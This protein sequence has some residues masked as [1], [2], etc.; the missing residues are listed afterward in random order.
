MA[1]TNVA[2]LKP[3]IS[4]TRKSQL[5]KKWL[6][7][8]M[9]LLAITCLV[10]A[11]AQPY[12][13]AAT[14]ETSQKQTVIYLD[15]S[16][17]MQASGTNGA[18]YDSAVKE[19]L[20]QLPANKEFT[21][22]TNDNTYPR[23]TKKTVSNQLLQSGYSSRKMSF[24]DIEL[25]AFSLLNDPKLTSEFIALSD[26]Q[27]FNNEDTEVPFQSLAAKKVKFTPVAVENISIDSAFL[28]T[29]NNG[30]LKVMLSSNF[31]N[32][33]PVTLTLENQNLLVS[34]TAVTLN[35][36]SALA[37][38]DLPDLE[39]FNGSLSIQD[40]GLQF[41]NELFLSF[42][43]SQQINVLAI[44]ESDDSFLKKIFNDERFNLITRP[45]AQANYN[46]IKDQN[47]VILNE[48][49]SIPATLANEINTLTNNG[50]QVLIIPSKTSNNY[51]ALTKGRI[52]ILAED[53]KKITTINYDHPIFK[54]VFNKRVENF[55][56]P[57]VSFKTAPIYAT[58]S[59]LKFEDGSSFLYQNDAVFIFTAPI[60]QE[61]S[62]FQNSPI[63]VPVLYNMAM[64]S[65][66]LPEL[67]QNL[68]SNK[69][70]AIPV[71][72]TGDDILKITTTAGQEFIP[73]QRSYNTYTVITAGDELS[74]AGNYEVLLK[75]ATVGVLSFND[76][77]A[78]NNLDYF[79][80]EEL[81]ADT[82]V[83][84]SDLFLDLSDEEK[85]NTLWAW[86]IA[87]T[88][89]FLCCELLILKFVK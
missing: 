25:K 3:L 22:F 40:S 58:N 41:D 13:P 73:L 81:G 6:V 39:K 84:V 32:Q 57:S 65:L 9:R 64:S 76:L 69:D 87:G 4:Q 89:F 62:N 72:A 80:T 17:S 15:N 28:S 18:L 35:D 78:E 24:K 47:F 63:I 30:Q 51:A 50:G 49:E 46:L 12:F 16:Y 70:I 77:R 5:L 61:N 10:L 42:D 68:Y 21:L 11:F 85:I 53:A 74:T 83:T 54:D 1:F 19:L 56:Y 43:Q 45:F 8:L 88:L 33:R 34:K 79:T 7:L 23:V 67:Y 44:N 14:V 60:N 37:T 66:P 52:K 59:I 26:F 2:F 38:F 36:G 27:K 82:Y 55:Q 75:A 48:L 86:F 20:D 29:E 71:A 31:D